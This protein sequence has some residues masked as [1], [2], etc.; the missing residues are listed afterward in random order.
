MFICENYREEVFQIGAIQMPESF[1]TYRELP[2]AHASAIIRF[3][4]EDLRFGT[5][6]LIREALVVGF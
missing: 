6:V 5:F 4:G 1:P 2:R 3:H